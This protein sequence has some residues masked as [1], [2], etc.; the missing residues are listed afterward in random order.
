MAWLIVCSIVA[1]LVKQRSPS[2]IRIW[3]ARYSQETMPTMQYFW[4]LAEA[5]APGR[6]LRLALLRP[7]DLA[8]ELLLVRLAGLDL[9]GDLGVLVWRHVVLRSCLCALLPFRGRLVLLLLLL[10]ADSLAAWKAPGRL[11]INSIASPQRAAG[12]FSVRS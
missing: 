11:A 12:C 3:N 5:A 9:R 2:L 10:L 4:R 7:L 6:R 1:S 8:G